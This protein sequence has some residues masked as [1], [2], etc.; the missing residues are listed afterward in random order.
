M[1]PVREQ[2]ARSSLERKERLARCGEMVPWRG[3]CSK[4]MA[5]TR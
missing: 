4:S 2:L 5:V 1:E 3:T